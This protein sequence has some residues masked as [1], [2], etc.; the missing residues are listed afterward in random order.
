[1]TRFLF[2]EILHEDYDS[3]V[4]N[5]W[6]WNK[7]AELD[8][9]KLPVVFVAIATLITNVLVIVTFVR[10]NMMSA[11][12]VILIGLS[13]SDTLTVLVPAT[14]IVYMY[15]DGKM[16]D[17][18]PYESCQLWGYLTKYLPTITHNA[19]IWLTVVLAYDRFIAIRHPFLLR[20]LCMPRRSVF[21]IM[22]IYILA[23]V[24]HFCRFIDTKYLPVKLVSIKSWNEA[25][26]SEYK[27]LNKPYSGNGSYS[28]AEMNKDTLSEIC[29]V[30]RGIETCRAV[31]NP[32]FGDFKFYE[33]CYYWFVILFVKF[34]P[35]FTMI[36]L[37]TM[38]LKSLH[39][40]EQMRH[41]MS[42]QNLNSTTGTGSTVNGS[43]F[44]Q[45]R[46]MTV[47]T[48]IAIIIV[49][50]VEVPIGVI[51]MF[52]TF[53]EVHGQEFLSERTTSMLA[54][55]ANYVVYISYP[56]IFILYCCIS[57]KFRSSFCKLCC[58]G[59]EKKC[60]IGINAQE[61]EQLQI[62]DH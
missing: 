51:L 35:C 22:G 46:R 39:H 54:R 17:F 20:R 37:D 31:Y 32:V 26:T 61:T 28:I 7:K 4:L 14:A 11:I 6:A 10:E 27:H 60:T 62:V 43:R 45:R 21:I 50:I 24:C 18:I 23:T 36:V 34:I 3:Y 56:I 33:F 38:M 47:I 41:F 12:N 15:A 16:P 42:V 55:V 5:P 49:A 2:S 52:W 8:I 58:K 53:S 48:I 29:R 30:S 57:A 1:M 25:M 40:A 19:S 44:Y 9:E 59:N 13:V